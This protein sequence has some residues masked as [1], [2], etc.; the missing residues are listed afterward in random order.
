[1]LAK[2]LYYPDQAI[3]IQYRLGGG[4]WVLPQNIYKLLPL[5]A[6]FG[7]DCEG[8]AVGMGCSGA[9]G[10]IDKTLTWPEC[11]PPSLSQPRRLAPQPVLAAALSPLANLSRSAQARSCLN[12]TKP[13]MIKS[14]RSFVYPPLRIATFHAY[15]VYK[16]P[17]VQ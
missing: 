17:D 4:V 5:V 15:A 11:R 3:L 16:C 9:E 1:M 13:S 10:G 14:K 2:L 7:L 12:L 6:A 8:Y